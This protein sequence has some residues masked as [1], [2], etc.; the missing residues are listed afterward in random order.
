MNIEKPRTRIQLK[1]TQ[2]ILDA[3][4]EVFSKHGFRGATLDQIAAEA[5]LSK[6]NLLYYFPSKESIH[7]NLLSQLMELGLIR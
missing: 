7:V 1:N 5:G 4:L 2:A 6:P 3:G